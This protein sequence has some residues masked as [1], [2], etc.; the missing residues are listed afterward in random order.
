[1]GKIEE[2]TDDKLETELI[3][4]R[5]IPAEKTDES[6][7]KEDELEGSNEKLDDSDNQVFMKICLV[8]FVF[9]S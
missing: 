8:L 7:T 1:M 4:K 3:K 6:D 9:N 5:K 2:V